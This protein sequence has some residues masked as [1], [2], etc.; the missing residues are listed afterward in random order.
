MP[1]TTS[2]L[3]VLA[4]HA[5]ARRVTHLD[6]GDVAD[7]DRDALLLD[8]DDVL[9]VVQRVAQRAAPAEEADAADVERLLAHAE[10]LAAHVGVGVLHAGD[11]LLERHPVAA[12]AVGIDGDL[13]LLGLA[14]VA[15]D[16]DHA[17]DLLE[18]A[19]EDPV[20]RRLEL[21]EGVTLALQ[22]VA[23]HLADGVPRR[24]GGLVAVG[25]LDE[26]EAVDDLLAGVL[27]LGVPVEVALH[28]RQ[29]EER[30]GADVREPRHAGEADLEG[31]RDVTLGLLAAPAVG[32]GDHLDEGRHRVGVGL[33]VEHLVRP[34][35]DDQQPGGERDHDRGHRQGKADQSLNHGVLERAAMRDA[36]A[37]GLRTLR[38]CI[39][40]PKP[41]FLRD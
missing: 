22:G 15:G 20:L 31:D 8:D 27:V 41:T 35:P 32:L 23:V 17:R 39:L 37:R 36:R 29:P 7:A 25:E 9:D 1:W 16:V 21:A 14:A 26:L 34:Q 24:D 38:W 40:A 6:A 4:D 3:V 30:L 33:D 11:E 13:V 28:V 10:P 19:L 12:E 2:S 18:L 5:E